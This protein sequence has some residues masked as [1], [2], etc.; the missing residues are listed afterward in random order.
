MR[1]RNR[2]GVEEKLLEVISEVDQLKVAAGIPAVLAKLLDMYGLTSVAYL[3]VG[4]SERPRHEP[5]LVV[6]YSPEWVKHYKAQRF[7]EVDP[8]IQV[9]LR[10]ILPVD[11]DAFDRKNEKVRRL[12]GEASEF[13]LGRRGISLPVHGRNGDRALLSITSD[14]G[15]RDWER[16]RLEYMRDLQLLALHMHQAI[17]RLE[18]RTRS[19]PPTLS[20]RER[21]CLQWTAEG[22]TS[23]EC[24]LILDISERTVRFYLES[25]RHKL[26]AANTAHAIAKASKANLLSDLP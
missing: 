13:G 20:P 24:A 17:L 10:R 8:A 12:F 4:L 16:L 7:V 5:Y 3:G 26:G 2:D 23:W 15:Q 11:W 14:A 18:G 9:G 19:E 6:T 21:E 22:K 1:M 25:A